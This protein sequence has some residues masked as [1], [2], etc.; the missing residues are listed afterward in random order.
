MK[1]ERLLIEADQKFH[2]PT[3]TSTTEAQKTIN[4]FLAQ[5]EKNILNNNFT[6]FIEDQG[7]EFET[8]LSIFISTLSPSAITKNQLFIAWKIHRLISLLFEHFDNDPAQYGKE[9]FMLINQAN[10][11][12]GNPNDINDVIFVMIEASL[13]L[14]LFLLKKRLQICNRLEVLNEDETGE[15]KASIKFIE[16]T[17]FNNLIENFRLTGIYVNKKNVF[18]MRWFFEHIEQWLTLAT[19]YQQVGNSLMLQN[20]I[21]GASFHFVRAIH[22]CNKFVFPPD[23]DEKLKKLKLL[24]LRKLT[25]KCAAYIG[26]NAFRAYF[27]EHEKADYEKASN[28]LII[29][30]TSSPE[31]KTSPVTKLKSEN[32]TPSL[33]HAYEM[34]RETEEY[35]MLTKKLKDEALE[36]GY[37]TEETKSDG[38]CLYV[39]IAKHLNIT[40][41]SLKE[42]ML[43]HVV[44]NYY[45]YLDV[46]PDVNT[47]IDETMPKGKWGEFMHAVIISRAYQKNIILV[48]AEEKN[49]IVIKQNEEPEEK[50]IVLGYIKN[51]HY[52]LLVK[53]PNFTG[54]KSLTAFL[55]AAEIDKVD[56]HEVV[57]LQKRLKNLS[58]DSSS[59]SSSMWSSSSSS[60]SSSI[61]SSSSTSASTSTSASIS[62]LSPSP[63]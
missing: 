40:V 41:E 3:M 62:T 15:D 28:E 25:I 56:S 16:F 32:Y 27:A 23:D 58:I 14:N 6:A 17:E 45:L 46:I 13:E 34:S 60:S 43:D 1:E 54:K 8:A 19:I 22:T 35:K 7:D 21:E 26:L 24:N 37:K 5:F 63:L 50:A 10:T 59:S 47:F 39:S 33:F 61:R 2:E 12:L 49:T 18:V 30:S 20:K 51:L 11:I 48:S 4:S 53:I 29:L 31:I 52:N 44:D 38:D 55:K 42:K 57:E 36:Y 9:I